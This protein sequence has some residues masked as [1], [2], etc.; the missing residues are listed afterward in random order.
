MNNFQ[1]KAIH[2]YIVPALLAVF[3]LFSLLTACSG[4]ING[5]LSRDGGA[6]LSLEISL[7]PRMS[8]LIRSLSAFSA[9]S[10]AGS[11]AGSSAGRSGGAPANRDAPIINGP[12]IARSMAAAP[13]IEAVSLLN[14]S[15]SS[16]AGNVRISRID[17]FL[18][19]PDIVG[20]GNTAGEPFITW[21][22]RFPGDSRLLI[23]MTRDTAPLL[24]TMISEDIRDYLSA[25]FAP[26][27]TGERLSRGEYLELVGSI[28]GQ[29]L[30]DEIAAA[31]ITA[32]IGFPGPVRSIKG[33]TFSGQEARFDIALVDLLV[34]ENPL[35]YEVIWR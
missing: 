14:R 10:F 22:P 25:L 6:E 28:Y 32:S 8:A 31:K 2:F 15:P 1:K 17:E 5:N 27:A 7:E 3:F 16:V 13:G 20:A 19:L 29:A 33:G 23:T 24:L 26:A 30:A 4:R 12:V 11:S 9:G 34:L 18:I 21:E 35:E